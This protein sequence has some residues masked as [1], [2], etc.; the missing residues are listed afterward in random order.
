[1]VLLVLM[2]VLGLLAHALSQ[3]IKAKKANPQV[4]VIGYFTENGLQTGLA[5][6]FAIVGFIA[7]PELHEAF[8]DAMGA[9]GIKANLTPLNAFLIGFAANFIADFFGNRF[10]AISGAGK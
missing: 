8:P 6:V 2:L 1:M 5:V 3:I 10:N 4:T 9:L 7:L